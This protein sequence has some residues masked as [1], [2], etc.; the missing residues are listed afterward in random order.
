MVNNLKT[1]AKRAGFTGKALAEERGI[2][3]E[4]VSRHMTGRVRMSLE[5]AGEYAAILGCTAEDIL[6]DPRTVPVFGTCDADHVVTPISAADGSL[7]V[8]FNLTMTPDVSAIIKRNGAS[9]WNNGTIYFIPLGPVKA[10]EVDARTTNRLSVYRRETGEIRFGLIY[11]E[12]A[13]LFT[14]S[15][16]WAP[17]AVEQNLTLQ[18]ATPVLLQTYQNE[19]L[20]VEEIDG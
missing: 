17:G 5:D 15:D 14:V 9:A 1:I 13:G 3:P 7:S 6:F 18:W 8:T 20:G 11:P 19:L 2:T 16:P 12:P 10:K 4:T